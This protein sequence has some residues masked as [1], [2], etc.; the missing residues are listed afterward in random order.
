MRERW[1]AISAL[2]IGFDQFAKYLSIQRLSLVNSLSV[3]PGF[4]LTLRYN[5]GAAFSLFANAFGWQ[6]WFLIGFALVI[7]IFIYVWLGRLPSKEKQ[8]GLALSLILGGAVGNLLDRIFNGYVT[9]F[10]LFHYKHWEWPAFNLADTAIC[11]GV[12][13]L[14][15]TLFKR[16]R[17]TANKR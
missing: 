16:P 13:L 2:V 5:R 14:I 8:E 3:F 15:P 4:D 12:C 17:E 11:I 6:R 7:S 1:L 10:L 9:D